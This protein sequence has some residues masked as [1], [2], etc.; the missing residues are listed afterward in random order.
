MTIGQFGFW[1]FAYLGM[2]FIIMLILDKLDNNFDDDM[3]PPASQIFSVI[4]LWPIFLV[5]AFYASIQDMVYF[6]DFWRKI[7]RRRPRI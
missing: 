5:F 6:E 1:V 7:T 2:G 3:C 4:F